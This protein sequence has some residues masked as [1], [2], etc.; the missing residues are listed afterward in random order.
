[1][2]MRLM[3]KYQLETLY[4]AYGVKGQPEVIWG[5]RGEKVILPPKS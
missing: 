3:H 5:H 2:T 1:M 4:L